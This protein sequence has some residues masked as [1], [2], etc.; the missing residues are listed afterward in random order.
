[1]PFREIA[2]VI[3]KH[4][5]LPVVSISREEADAHF[6]FLGALAGLDIPSAIPG[7][8]APTRELLGWQPVHPTLIADLEQGHYFKA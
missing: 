7:S 1:M 3:G 8:S 6:G 2:E 5:N 4:L